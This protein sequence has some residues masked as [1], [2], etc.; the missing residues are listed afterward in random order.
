LWVAV[1]CRDAAEGGVLE[2][3]TTGVSCLGDG[4]GCVIFFPW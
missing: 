3:V 2:G 4:I 1:V